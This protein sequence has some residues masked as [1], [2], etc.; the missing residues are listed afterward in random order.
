MLERWLKPRTESPDPEIR[1]Q[2]FAEV[3]PEH[4]AYKEAVRFDPD[5]SVRASLLARLGDLPLLALRVTEEGDE[6]ALLAARE[7]LAALLCGGSDAPAVEVRL[8]CLENTRDPQLLER[9]VRTSDD[10]RVRDAALSKMLAVQEDC[11]A[12]LVAVASGDGDVDL[13]RRAVDMLADVD[14]LDEVAVNVRKSDKDL[15]R[16]ARDKIRAIRDNQEKAHTRE[17]LSADVAELAARPLEAQSDPL[18]RRQARLQHLRE[19]WSRVAQ[20]ESA[21]DQPVEHALAAI[22]AQIATARE[23]VNARRTLLDAIGRDSA[24]ADAADAEPRWRE[25]W[26]QLI[27]HRVG[28]HAEFEKAVSAYQAR[29]RDTAR[30][31]NARADATTLLGEWEGTDWSATAVDDRRRRHLEE[32]WR[33]IALP[34]GADTELERRY[35]ALTDRLRDAQVRQQAAS[36]AAGDET[37][38]LIDELAKHLEAGRSAEATSAHDKINHRLSHSVGLPPAVA[39]RA[40]KRMAKLEPQLR[41]LKEWRHWGANQAREQLCGEAQALAATAADEKASKLASKVKALRESWRKID[42]GVGAASADLWKRFDT[43]CEAAY[44]PAKEAFDK[45]S[46]ERRE[47][48]AGKRA[49]CERIETYVKDTDW[50]D[51]DWQAATGLL[52]DCR[53][54][55]RSIGGVNHRQFLKLR[56]RYRRAVAALDEKL[57]DEREREVRRRALLIAALKKSTEREP[58]EAQIEAAKKTQ[59]EWRPTVRTKRKEEQVLW[60]SLREVCDAIFAQRDERHATRR[61]EE[62]SGRKARETLCDEIAAL[63]DGDSHDEQAVNQAA[64]R[65]DELRREWRAGGPVAPRQRAALDRRYR[66]ACRDFEARRDRLGKREHGRHTLALLECALLVDEISQRHSLGGDADDS[67]LRAA[68]EAL[69]ATRGALS[70]KLAGAFAAAGG[71]T[72]ASEENLAAKRALCLRLE[73]QA[74]VPTPPEYQAERMALKIALLRDA[75]SGGAAG[76]DEASLLTAI[77][78]WSDSAPVPADD[79]RALRDRFE[80]AARALTDAT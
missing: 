40:R 73:L 5:P 35:A 8:A 44:A 51:P 48:A 80:R 23:T 67:D 38:A 30:L 9:T 36:A 54:E 21:S 45:Q 39:A 66:Q 12:L 76:D 43:A 41:K 58:L 33:K 7:R 17:Q 16:R 11:R 50:S 15:H 69:P 72:A 46:E 59:R 55:W 24:A 61:Q 18:H 13:R 62:S 19:A 74:D 22:E 28:D 68:W 32:H 2:A 10:A 37:A 31:H 57:A 71:Q 4:P 49:V 70:K 20:D 25:E 26:S 60:E 78:Q 79:W 75:L 56:D 64:G 1:K 53:R 65:Y 34:E 77:A 52:D 47:N 63:L 29:R 6:A 42:K 14:A 3:D 27:D